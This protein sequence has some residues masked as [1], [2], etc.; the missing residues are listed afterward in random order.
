MQILTD[1]DRRTRQRI[2]ELD[3]EPLGRIEHRRVLPIGDGEDLLITEAQLTAERGTEVQSPQTADE[4]RCPQAGQQL[5]V[6][7]HRAT[8]GHPTLHGE[9]AEEGWLV[10]PRRPVRGRDLRAT[11]TGAKQRVD[12]RTHRSAPDMRTLAPSTA[13]AAI[14]VITSGT[15]LVTSWDAASRSDGRTT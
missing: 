3:H 2:G 5:Q 14:A 15:V 13:T 8:E 4:R 9:L 11:A 10:A 1:S 12:Q 7:R 6:D